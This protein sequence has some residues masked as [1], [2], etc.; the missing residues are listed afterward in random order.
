[1][2][3]H[4]NRIDFTLLFLFIFFSAYTQNDLKSFVVSGITK[5]KL[6][7]LKAAILDFDKAIGNALNFAEKNKETLVIVTADHETGGMA[8]TGGNM[9]EGTVTA[10]YTTTNHTGIM[11]PVFAY[12][13]GAELFQGIQENTAIFDKMMMLLGLD[14][15]VPGS[16]KL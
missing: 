13:P 11:V 16:K 12:G 10:N 8:I 14:S 5:A 4:L 7:D 15:N 6:G 3:I 9:S 1:M 2:H